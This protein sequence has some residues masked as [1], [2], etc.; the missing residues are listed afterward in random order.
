[1]IVIQT[2]RGS[3]AAVATASAFVVVI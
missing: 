1:M 2:G 3:A